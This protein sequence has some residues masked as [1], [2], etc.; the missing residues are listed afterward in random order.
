MMTVVMT[1]LKLEAT[2]HPPSYNQTT[3]IQLIKPNLIL[4]PILRKIKEHYP[5]FTRIKK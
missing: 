1:I 3:L 4:I 2:V 5:L